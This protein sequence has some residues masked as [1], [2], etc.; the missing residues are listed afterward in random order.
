MEAPQLTKA[1]RVK[2]IKKIVKRQKMIK[3][4]RVK[5]IDTGVKQIIEIRENGPRGNITRKEERPVM[6]RVTLSPVFEEVEKE[7][8]IYVVETEY[9][10]AK[11]IHEFTSRKDAKIFKEGFKS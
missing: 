7:E 8:D 4:A 5:D 11:E 6:E 3:P 1:G 9:E 10:G 2:K